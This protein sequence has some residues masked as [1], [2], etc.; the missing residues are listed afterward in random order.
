MDQERFFALYPKLPESYLIVAEQLASARA[1][2]EESESA[3]EGAQALRQAWD[4]RFD[5]V[6]ASLSES[7]AWATA[8]LAERWHGSDISAAVACRDLRGPLGYIAGL[9][10]QAG[11]ALVAWRKA[12]SS[13]VAALVKVRQADLELQ[14][15]RLYLEQIPALDAG[16]P[17][18][19]IPVL[20]K[21][22][23]ERKS[24]WAVRHVH[25][26]NSR[27][28]FERLQKEFD[29]LRT[30]LPRDSLCPFW[31]RDDPLR[32]GRPWLNRQISPPDLRGESS[33]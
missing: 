29:D 24:T 1:L 26:G 14:K 9:S 18:D 16:L 15:T 33:E 21:R 7:E 10:D 17:T 3:V 28:R 22:L 5:L 23:A 8:A 19:V 6:D 27:T 2:Y 11:A 30:G 25:S 13:E 32:E 12:Q 4:K 31:R 20:E